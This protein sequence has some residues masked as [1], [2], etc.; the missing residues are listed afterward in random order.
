MS[1]KKHHGLPVVPVVGD[2]WELRGKQR[3]VLSVSEINPHSPNSF[4][5]TWRTPGTDKVNKCSSSTWFDWWGY[6]KR[7]KAGE[8]AVPLPTPTEQTK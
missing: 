2:I 7:I 4:E 8:G 3:E 6:G 1:K 5:M